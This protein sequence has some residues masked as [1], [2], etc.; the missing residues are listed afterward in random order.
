NNP[1][2]DVIDNLT[3]IKGRHTLTMGGSFRHSPYYDRYDAHPLAHSFGVVSGDPVSSV[4]LAGLPAIN[5]NNSDFSNA[6]SL[7]AGLTGR[8]SNI[9]GTY[10]VDQ[11]NHQ[12]LAFTPQVYRY[13]FNTG[14]LYVQD[15]FGH[16]EP[17][18]QLRFPLAIRRTDQHYQRRRRLPHVDE[19]LRPVDA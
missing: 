16:I 17:D 18:S 12:Y 4:L 2:F 8:L 7:Y 10:A 5:Q 1:V 11:H 14:R 3:W 9:S 13:N 19:F 15:S 6:L